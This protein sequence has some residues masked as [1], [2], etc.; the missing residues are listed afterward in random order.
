MIDG[1]VYDISDFKDHPGGA[2]VLLERAGDDAST[3]FHRIGHS[4]NA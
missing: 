1:D 4:A 3:V 2:K